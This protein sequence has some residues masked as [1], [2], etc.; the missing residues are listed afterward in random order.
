MI[1]DAKT[2]QQVISGDVNAFEILL[3]RYRGHVMAVV[4]NHVPSNE[5]DDVSQNVFLRA[6]QSLATYREKG[7]FKNWLTGVAIR[8][9]YDFWRK[10]YKHKEVPI[11]NL[12][13][14]HQKWLD[15]VMAEQ[16]ADAYNA[17]QGKQEAQ[18]I[19]AWAL[20]R[21]SAADRMVLEL[22]YLE[23]M[24]G[25]EAAGYLGWSVANVKVRSYRARNK[26]KKIV[27]KFMDKGR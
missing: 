16:S 22:V 6:Y 10:K 4:I 24:S 25:K 26:L 15:S 12:S 20:N 23:G 2:I 18:E 11:S 1:T 27:T 19:L 9:C 5:V 3:R 7:S 14:R 17:A 21:L 8:T 13:E